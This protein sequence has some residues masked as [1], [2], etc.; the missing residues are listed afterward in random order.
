VPSRDRIGGEVHLET[1]VEQ[2]PVMLVSAHTT[3]DAVRRLEDGDFD[4]SFSK[5][6]CAGEAGQPGPD[7]DGFHTR[8]SVTHKSGD[9]VTAL[10]QG[11][12]GSKKWCAS[13]LPVEILIPL[14]T[15]RRGKI[16][17]NYHRNEHHDEGS[18]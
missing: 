6:F 8:E 15:L 13:L 1:P 18:S 11:E 5:Y 17:R 3:T 7:D 10:T 14:C 2:K 9:Q 4:S 16:A 12:V